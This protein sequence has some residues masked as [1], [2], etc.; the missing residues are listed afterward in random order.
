[1]IDPLDYFLISSI[2]GS[3]LASRLK[4]YLSEKASM[5]RLKRSIINKSNC[6][7]SKTNLPILN[8]KQAKTKKIYNFALRGG[9]F[10]PLVDELQAALEFSNE[11]FNL[12][13]QIKGIVERLA[14]FLK[15]KKIKRNCEHF[16]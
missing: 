16:F 10:N 5:E 1:M 2:I 13:Q 7:P 9:Q 12:A 11:I 6:P 14:T 4:N 15:E 8:I 3:I